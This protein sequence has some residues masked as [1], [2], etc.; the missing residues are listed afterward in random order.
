MSNP[1]EDEDLLNLTTY[2]IQG[3]QDSVWAN[4]ESHDDPLRA[5]RHLQLLIIDD[6]HDELRLIMARMSPISGETEYSHMASFEGGNASEPDDADIA[7]ALEK[8]RPW[9]PDYESLEFPQMSFWQ[10][11]KENDRQG[12]LMDLGQL[13]QE[14]L[15]GP[16]HAETENKPADE[17]M[18]GS[19]PITPLPRRHRVETRR[20]PSSG[21]D[22]SRTEPRPAR[23]RVAPLF[24]GLLAGTATLALA[25][26][27]AEPETGKR[28]LAAAEHEVQ[29]LMPSPSL[30]ALIRENRLPDVQKALA[31]GAD[32]N[33]KDMLDKPML[34][35]A[36]ERGA[37]RIMDSLYHAGAD[38]H[39]ALESGN[40][41][42]QEWAAAGDIGAIQRSL[43]AGI[44]PDSLHITGKCLTPLSTAIANGRLRTSILLVEGGASLAPLEGC[45]SGP[46]QLAM[47]Q[48]DILHRLSI[49]K[50]RIAVEQASASQTDEPELILI[51]DDRAVARPKTSS[52]ESV[53][54][55][56]TTVITQEAPKEEP[57]RN[58]LAQAL[59]DIERLP[60]S[61]Q[62]RTDT[63][64]QP[65]SPQPT[66][67]VAMLKDSPVKDVSDAPVLDGDKLAG[68]LKA[69]IDQADLTSARH[70]I[71]NWPGKLNPKEIQFLASD[72]WGS[73]LRDALDYALIRGQ[74]QISRILYDHG[75]RPSDQ[76]LHLALDNSADRTFEKAAFFLIRSGAEVNGKQDG[77]TPLMRAL[78][79]GN[80]ELVSELLSAGAR[81]DIAAANGE[82]ALDFARR[83]GRD[84]MI[85]L[86]GEESGSE[87]YRT[88]MMGLSWSDRR[89]DL[90]GRLKECRSLMEGFTS[91]K[92]ANVEW[93]P[94]SV[95]IIAQFDDRNDG[96]L[97]ALQIDSQLMDSPDQAKQLFEQ[98][99]DAI[100]K[101]LPGNITPHQSRAAL[102]GPDFFSSL[103][104]GSNGGA[105]FNYWS[106]QDKSRPVYIHLKLSGYDAARGYYRILIGNPYRAG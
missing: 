66:A 33:S 81:T 74:F 99:A 96:R 104:P 55:V 101:R 54:P 29:L 3:S 79:R 47:L 30:A 56:D 52:A 6:K 43:E 28:M 42:M 88:V 59:L 95:S 78:I 23:K 27:L 97:S 20:N 82:T 57:P 39:L 15:A 19:A 13:H 58:I 64:K 70:L 50:D 37:Y 44:P 36:A 46:L 38:P 35:I 12:T 102:D 68:Y 94:A 45:S 25:F 103:Q 4:I 83:S 21:R 71:N 90:K 9:D 41:I 7:S 98:V 60:E 63:A 65:S 76:M 11:E 17:E 40:S 105:Y 34:V 89:K 72:K 16:D 106:D 69:A 77:L 24:S 53:E 84:E 61:E 51:S 100:S 93:L 8:T 18:I 49:L 1:D 91:C 22:L 75:F 73:G 85:A 86:I 92:L 31:R 10:D 87:D 14:N 26:G 5:I 32:P 80:P 62:E 48:P 67:K 2:W